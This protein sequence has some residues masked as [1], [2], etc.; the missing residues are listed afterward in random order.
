MYL[1]LIIDTSIK[2]SDKT[3]NEYLI[4]IKTPPIYNIIYDINIM[5]F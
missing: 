3:L 1:S 5:F 2:H 4:I